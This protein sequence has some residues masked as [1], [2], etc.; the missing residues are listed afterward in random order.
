MVGAFAF[1]EHPQEHAQQLRVLY[2]WSHYQ[3]RALYHLQHNTVF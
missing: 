2:V 3:A 1:V